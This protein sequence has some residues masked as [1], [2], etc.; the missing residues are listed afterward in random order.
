MEILI[1]RMTADAKIATLKDERKV[2]NFSIAI[3]D[4]YRQKGI[5]Q[6]KKVVT[7]VSC[8]YW[9]SS[10]IAE[11]LKKGTLVELVG[12]ISV[13]AYNGLEGEPK[14]TLNFHV[15]N[16]KLHGTPGKK[17]QEVAPVST[18]AIEKNS[19]KKKVTPDATSVTEPI[20]DL[21]F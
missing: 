21:P 19:K 18:D 11:H 16:I 3:N 17:E 14:A 1:G 20:D 9:I 12:R 8:S 6:L 15:N 13:S 7:F 10:G 4:S 2:V 5:E